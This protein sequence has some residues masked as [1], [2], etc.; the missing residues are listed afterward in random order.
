MRGIEATD[1]ALAE[2][3]SA[4]AGC[5]LE[6]DAACQH[7]SHRRVGVTKEGC[8]ASCRA[9]VV[10]RAKGFW[11]NAAERI[12]RAQA[13]ELEIEI[14]ALPFERRCSVDWTG[15]EG[16]FTPGEAGR[17]LAGIPAFCV[18]CY[19][20]RAGSEELW[21]SISEKGGP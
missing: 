13:A 5:T 2:H 16:R 11:A 9:E 21:R 1:G 8:S 20:I 17:V 15:I 19:S 14:K 3:L 4:Q 6:R 10:D 12:D 7:K 18:T